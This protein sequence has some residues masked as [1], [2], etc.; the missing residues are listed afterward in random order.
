MSKALDSEKNIRAGEL[1][2]I[3]VD[4]WEDRKTV[5][6]FLVLKD[7][8]PTDEIQRFLSSSSG[9]APNTLVRCG[10]LIRVLLEQGLLVQV[11][12][13]CLDLAL[14]KNVENV[15]FESPANTYADTTG[16]PEPTALLQATGL[17]PG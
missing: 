11:R 17:L 7:F 6:V 9:L 10:Q 13:S 15:T 16:L 1:L 5:G 3:D 8:C 14:M 4:G 12:T 2:T